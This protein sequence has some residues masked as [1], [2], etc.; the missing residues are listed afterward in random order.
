[1]QCRSLVV[2]LTPQVSAAGFEPA[3]T[4]VLAAFPFAYTDVCG[5]PCV[6]PEQVNSLLARI[7]H[8][9]PVPVID[10]LPSALVPGCDP[11]V[12]AFPWSCW[13]SNPGPRPFR[14]AVLRTR[15]AYQ[16]LG[17]VLMKMSQ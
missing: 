4:S 11:S 8:S 17:N 6:I 5:N 2:L 12:Y 3:Y 14:H 9:S 13:K 7:I 15:R 10:M 1:M 16:P